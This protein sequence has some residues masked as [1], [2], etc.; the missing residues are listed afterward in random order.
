[1]CITSWSPDDGTILEGYRKLEEIG[2]SI[3]PK[4]YCSSMLP[5]SF[6]FPGLLRCEPCLPPVTDEIISHCEPEGS[7]LL[8]MAQKSSEVLGDE[9][10]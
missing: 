5:V 3:G 6:L 2:P 4:V 9:A 10:D 1:M 8:V 7:S